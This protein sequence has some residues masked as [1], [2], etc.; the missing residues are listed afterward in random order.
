MISV[1][2]LCEAVKRAWEEGEETSG[3]I[4][5]GSLRK[6]AVEFLLTLTLEDTMTRGPFDCGSEPQTQWGCR[7]DTS[8]LMV[9]KQWRKFSSSIKTWN[10]HNATVS[11]LK[12]AALLWST[13]TDLFRCHCFCGQSQTQTIRQSDWLHVQH[14]KST[15]FM[16]L[17]VCLFDRVFLSLS[18]TCVIKTKLQDF[19][20]V[21]TK[22]WDLLIINVLFL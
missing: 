11:T 8:C 3:H 16:F 7:K 6:N 10:T 22:A 2:S 12:G 5:K 14:F 15:Y 1:G 19:K 13:N 17:F 18:F 20:N 9:L 4:I 21:L